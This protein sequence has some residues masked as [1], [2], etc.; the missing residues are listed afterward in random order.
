[1]AKIYFS[2]LSLE[3]SSAFSLLVFVTNV[4]HSV[5]YYCFLKSC[6][7]IRVYINAHWHNSACD[8]NLFLETFINVHTRDVTKTQHW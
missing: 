3:E 4:E 7:A 8:Q 2:F 5:A 1:M 6:H